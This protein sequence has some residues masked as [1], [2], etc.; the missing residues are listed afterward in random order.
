MN[1]ED[2]KAEIEELA[3]QIDYHNE[4]YYQKHTSEISDFEFDQRIDISQCTAVT[5]HRRRN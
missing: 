4:L 3:R 1:K 2:I 5:L